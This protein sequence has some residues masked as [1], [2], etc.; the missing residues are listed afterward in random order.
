MATKFVQ[1]QNIHDSKDFLKLFWEFWKP[2]IY[3]YIS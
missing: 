1:D 3:A 2:G